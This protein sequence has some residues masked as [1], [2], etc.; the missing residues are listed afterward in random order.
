[1]SAVAQIP[2]PMQK[3]STPKKVPVPGQRNAKHLRMERSI[4]RELERERSRTALELHAGAGQPLSGI[5]LNL[6]I[7]SNFAGDLPQPAREALARLR[8]LADQAL[9]QVRAVSHKLYPPDWQALTT[10]DAILH[11]VQTSGLPCT[12]QLDLDICPLPLEP[13]HTVKVILYRCAQECISNVA[14]HSGA[15]RFT[16]SL[17][18]AGPMIRLCAEDNGRGFPKNSPDRA[19]I[20]LVAIREHAARLGGTCNISSGSDGVRICVELPFAAE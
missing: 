17:R 12:L 1:V 10:G 6:E 5:K 7:L 16:L 14:R 11:L 19:G 15:T 8:S 18:A 2:G 3:S 4:V 20:G 13:S 9:E